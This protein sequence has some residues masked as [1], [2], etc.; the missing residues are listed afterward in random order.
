MRKNKETKIEKQVLKFNAVFLEEDNGG[1]S[2][3]VPTLP[4]CFSQG[5]T[6]EEAMA[7]IKEAIELYLEDEQEDR[8][9]LKYRGS[10][11]FLV[12]VELYG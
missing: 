4:G 11:E 5:D 8:E 6:F 10:R 3:N 12:P 7:N 2:V 9:L 1:Y